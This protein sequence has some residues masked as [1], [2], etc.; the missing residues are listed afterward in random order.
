MPLDEAP[1]ASLL[2]SKAGV[3]VQYECSPFR[4]TSLA[5][6]F[7]DAALRR[8]TDALTVYHIDN[9]RL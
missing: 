1:S 8:T 7:H 5:S 2:S 9:T 3:D 6:V 4:I